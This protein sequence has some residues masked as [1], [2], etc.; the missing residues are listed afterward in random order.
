MNSDDFYW[1]VLNK[2]IQLPPNSGDKAAYLIGLY[3]EKLT[4][5]QIEHILET[6]RRYRKLN[7]KKSKVPT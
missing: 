4:A 7:R 5:E 3:A 1:E 2:L 6:Y